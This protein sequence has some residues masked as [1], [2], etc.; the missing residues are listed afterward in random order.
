MKATTQVMHR[1]THVQCHSFKNIA[2]NVALSIDLP[3]IP[4]T[5]VATKKAPV[6]T[7]RKDNILLNT[8]IKPESSSSTSSPL[9]RPI[10]LAADRRTK[11]PI[12]QTS[13]QNPQGVVR[14]SPPYTMPGS[15]LSQFMLLSSKG[16]RLFPILTISR[17]N[18]KD[19]PGGNWHP[20]LFRPQEALDAARFVVENFSDNRRVWSTRRQFA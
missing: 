10:H 15:P 13:A 4:T 2:R 20:R 11:K 16:C 8:F 19:N 3:A 12:K 9:V 14:T 7:K 1:E 18:S 17:L 5:H 6:H